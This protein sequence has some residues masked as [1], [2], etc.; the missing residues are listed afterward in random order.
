MK[1]Q[2]RA[3]LIL[4]DPMPEKT[5]GGM[6]IPRTAKDTQNTGVVV[7]CGPECELVDQGDKIIFLKK[8][9]SKVEIDGVEHC[10]GLESCIQYIYE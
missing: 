1:V 2:G 4:P 3:V 10:F 6:I 7:D 8:T 9:T 5:K